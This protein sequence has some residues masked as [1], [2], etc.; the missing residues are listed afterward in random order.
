MIVT[1]TFTSI[2]FQKQVQA[3]MALPLNVTTRLGGSPG[4][5]ATST[6]LT[7]ENEALLAFRPSVKSFFM[8]DSRPSTLTHTAQSW[9]L[10][11]SGSGPSVK[12]PSH[13]TRLPE[14][15][16]SLSSS[17]NSTRLPSPLTAAPATTGD[18]VTPRAL[19]SETRSSASVCGGR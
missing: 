4:C 12:K 9:L 14:A 3:S 11:K 15:A 16:T 7:R 5:H 1:S 8:D 13:E 2:L 19:T 18:P 17:R 10:V 6:S